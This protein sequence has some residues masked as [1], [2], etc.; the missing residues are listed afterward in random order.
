MVV[1]PS[2]QSPQPSGPC[3]GAY[4]RPPQS[5][6]TPR[7]TDRPPEGLRA[8]LTAIGVLRDPLEQGPEGW[9]DWLLPDRQGLHGDEESVNHLDD[10]VVVA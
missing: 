3:V 7:Q 9:G 2:G 1:G 8:Y 4:T 10:A 5:V 6:N